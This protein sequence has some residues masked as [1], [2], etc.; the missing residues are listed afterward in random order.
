MSS[1]NSYKG[2]DEVGED[3]DDDVEEEDASSSSTITSDAE[4]DNKELESSSKVD[5]MDSESEQ[6]P[7][8]FSMKTH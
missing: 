5:S 3:D 1:D 8:P 4:D 2:P 6:T 7:F